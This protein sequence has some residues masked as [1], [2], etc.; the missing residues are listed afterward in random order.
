[1][2]ESEWLTRTDPQKM[3]EFLRGKASDRKLRLF[4]VACCRRVWHLLV[5]KRSRNAVETAERFA[6]SAATDQELEAVRQDAWEFADH[7]VHEDDHFVD[8]NADALNAGNRHA[9]GTHPGRPNRQVKWPHPSRIRSTGFFD[10][11]NLENGGKDAYGGSLRNDSTRPSR[12]HEHSR[13]RSH[14]SSL[15]TQDSA[16]PSGTPTAWLHTRQTASCSCSGILSSRH[17][18]HPPGR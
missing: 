14:F 11:E 1:M 8:L 13:H 12:R 7:I 9:K 16:N 15:P 18:C 5:D 3:L 17:R 10:L 4:V 2:K 6:D